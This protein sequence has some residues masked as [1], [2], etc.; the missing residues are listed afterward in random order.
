M[1]NQIKD[2]DILIQKN[3]VPQILHS[4]STIQYSETIM[5]VLYN[6]L[7]NLAS[8]FMPETSKMSSAAL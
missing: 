8:Q 5:N 7:I 1:N 3:L 6:D 2:C 4:R